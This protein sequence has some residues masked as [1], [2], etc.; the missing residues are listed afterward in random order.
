ME[1]LDLSANQLHLL[2]A[3]LMATSMNKMRSVTLVDSGI[4]MSQVQENCEIIQS[5]YSLNSGGSDSQGKFGENLTHH[6]LGLSHSAT[7]I[8]SALNF[9]FT[10]YQINY[11][12]RT[13]G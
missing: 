11:C 6:F 9:G 13:V 4:T 1:E 10:V 5:L 7:S 12:R 8:F 2:N 3:E